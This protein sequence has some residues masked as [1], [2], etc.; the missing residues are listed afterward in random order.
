ML[1]L[2][3]NDVRQCQTYDRRG[4]FL[5]SRN[6]VSGIISSLIRRLEGLIGLDV[7]NNIMWSKTARGS[8]LVMTE[9]TI[10]G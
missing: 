10:G 8:T 9:P 1:R 7:I 2:I 3:E 5:L 4:L 6:F